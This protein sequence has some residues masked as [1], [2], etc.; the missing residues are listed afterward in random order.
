[1]KETWISIDVETSGAVPGLYDLVS[2][3]ASVIG[4]GGGFYA[5]LKPHGGLVDP[6]A[7]AVHGLTAE[8]LQTNG[9]DPKIVMT[10]FLE[11]IKVVAGDT[12]PV[13]ASWGSFDW[14]WMGY[15][16]EK[17]G[18]KYVVPFGP[19]SLELKSFY[20]G[21]TKQTVWRKAQK[22]HM[23]AEDLDDNPNPHNALA[24]AMSQARMVQGW[25]KKYGKSD[26]VAGCCGPRAPI[27]EPLQGIEYRD[28]EPY[29]SFG[30]RGV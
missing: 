18:K 25:L 27:S 11:W 10:Q 6:E 12:R 28:G 30:P 22:R 3:G 9:H 15:Y 19:N 2:I 26:E 20:L 23:P 17:F 8:Y 24:D 14:M 21:L 16:L 5:E 29:R 13:F 4:S 7:T 1:M